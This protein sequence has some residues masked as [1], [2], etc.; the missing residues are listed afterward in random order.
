MGRPKAW[1]EVAET[2]LLRWM[3]ERLGPAFSEVI[4]SFAE[5]EQLEEHVPYRLV[6]D[7]RRAAGP[8]AGI[9]AGLTA[10]RH[11]V[12]FAIACDM[13]YVTRGVAEMAVAAARGCD[14]AMPRFGGRAEPVCAAYRRSSLA[15]VSAALDGGRLKAADICDHLD[16]TWL[17]GLDPDLFRSLN[18]LD[19][20]QRFHD[21]LAAQ[22]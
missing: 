18:T 10:A 3:V 1:L 7:R 19:D 17:E 4:V 11:E 8:L 9:E 12:T 15:A 6:F 21:G 14:A 20:Y 13:P 22:R 5:P 16:V 2:T